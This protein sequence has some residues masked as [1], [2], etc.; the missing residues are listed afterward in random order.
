M[1][2][3]KACYYFHPLNHSCGTW[4]RVDAVAHLLGSYRS[5]T[6]KATYNR[7]VSTTL[8]YNEASL[9]I[10]AFPF[11]DAFRRAALL[12]S[13]HV[14][15]VTSNSLQSTPS[16]VLEFDDEISRVLSACAKVSNKVMEF[17]PQES[18]V[19][20][21]SCLEYVPAGSGSHDS[22]YDMLRCIIDCCSS[23][24]SSGNSCFESGDNSTE[25]AMR[26]DHTVY[27]YNAGICLTGSSLSNM[28]RSFYVNSFLPIV[29]GVAALFSAI[30]ENEIGRS[31]RGNGFRTGS[32]SSVS[33]RSQ[34]SS[35]TTVQFIS[36]GDGERQ[37]IHSRVIEDLD[38]IETLSVLCD[39]IIHLLDTFDSAMEYAHGPTP[40]YSLSK[41]MMN[42]AALLLQNMVDKFE[43]SESVRIVALCPGNFQVCA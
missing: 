16:Y 19:P 2:A 8:E 34:I 22:D 31:S 32:G 14:Q 23:L 33:G 3:M 37:M 5:D 42:K 15:T 17:F 6:G 25:R 10:S 35:L 13:K 4:K 29:V 43:L 26:S 38:R 27:L 18:V 11:Q 12:M 9:K 21:D 41:L 7:I 24:L 28:A 39:Y 40:M 1:I 36:S 30:S 20:F